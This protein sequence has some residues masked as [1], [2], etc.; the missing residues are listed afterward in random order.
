MNVRW[1]CEPVKFYYKESET[2]K[3]QMEKRKPVDSGLISMPPHLNYLQPKINP[4]ILLQ[5]A[6]W[7]SKVTV[8]RKCHQF[9]WSSTSTFNFLLRS[10]FFKFLLLLLLQSLQSLKP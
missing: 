3:V 6:S 9:Y 4:I 8:G 10:S 5:I 2:R 7:R 1:P